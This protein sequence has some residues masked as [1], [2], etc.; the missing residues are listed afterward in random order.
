M[1]QVN[2]VSRGPSR[3]RRPTMYPHGERD[4]VAFELPAPD[5]PSAASADPRC[6]KVPAELRR[7]VL[8]VA[9]RAD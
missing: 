2:G 5:Q 7:A 8:D 4:A 1:N 9:V 3:R 6:D